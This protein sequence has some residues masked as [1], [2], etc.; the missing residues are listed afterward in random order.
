M[1]ESIAKNNVNMSMH[2]SSDFEVKCLTWKEM[3]KNKKLV[4]V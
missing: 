3:A 2:L 1:D 4:F